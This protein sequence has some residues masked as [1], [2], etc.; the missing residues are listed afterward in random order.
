MENPLGSS[1]AALMD[2]IRGRLELFESNLP[3]RVD[4]FAVSSISKLP[5]KVL[6]YREALI[7]RMAE[8]GR[9]ALQN[10]EQ[11][12]LVAAIVL[13]RAAV[14]TTSALWFLWAKVAAAVNANVIGDIDEYLMKFV[15][16]TATAAP[17]AQP[18]DPDLP[19]P[20]RVG[21]FLKEVEKDIPGFTH[22]YGVLSEYAHPNWAGTVLLY[23][24][25]DTKNLVTDFGK[26]IRCGDNAKTIGVG[27]LSVA[28]MIFESQ[29]NKIADLIPAFTKLSESSGG[30]HRSAA[31]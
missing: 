14:E 24:K 30:L 23:A 20:V 18:T 1:I 19:R 2:E 11:D 28:L 4:A 9:A 22:Q 27:N 16:G 25:H 13:T 21:T 26:N 8:L 7:W 29:Y 3:K 5:S 10:F 6:W 15:V 12:T 17:N 31:P